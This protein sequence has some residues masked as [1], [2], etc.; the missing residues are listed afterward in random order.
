MRECPDCNAVLGSDGS[1][2]VHK[3]RFHRAVAQ[4]VAQP[5]NAPTV[6]VQESVHEE[7]VKPP[8]WITGAKEEPATTKEEQKQP[9][10]SSAPSSS[11]DGALIAGTAIGLI[12]VG[13]A[14]WLKNRKPPEQ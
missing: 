10:E 2:R 13:V 9:V 7:Y 14:W 11:G 8:P 6:E 12:L 4:V 5:N 1:Y 3:H